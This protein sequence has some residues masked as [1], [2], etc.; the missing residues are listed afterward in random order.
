MAD[1]VKMV[2]VDGVRY[3]EEDAPKT[4]QAEPKNKSRKPADKAGPASTE[5]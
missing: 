3:R 5:K 1:A 2:V 4:K